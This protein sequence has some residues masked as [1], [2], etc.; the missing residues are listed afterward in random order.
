MELVLGEV[1]IESKASF[2]EGGF[3]LDGGRTESL[4]EHFGKSGDNRGFLLLL[5]VIRHDAPLN[6]L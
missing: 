5:G 6:I 1:K 4:L 2:L 3:R